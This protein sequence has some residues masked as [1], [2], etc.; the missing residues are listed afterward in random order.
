MIDPKES[1]NYVFVFIA[2]VIIAVLLSFNIGDQIVNSEYY[3]KQ[4]DE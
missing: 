2:L 4:R 3:I 1:K